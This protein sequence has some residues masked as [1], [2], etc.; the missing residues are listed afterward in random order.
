MEGKG[1]GVWEEIGSEPT[2]I[3]FS[4]ETVAEAHSVF[5]ECHVKIEGVLRDLKKNLSFFGK[6]I[7][8]FPFPFEEKLKT[9]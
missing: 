9:R 7:E 6:Y 8:R 2:T 4:D 5:A 1:C 3:C